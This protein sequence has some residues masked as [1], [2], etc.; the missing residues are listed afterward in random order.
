MSKSYSKNYVSVF[1]F[2]LIIKL[3][4]EHNLIVIGLA[5]YLFFY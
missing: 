5:F 3:F 4:N 1:R 2:N